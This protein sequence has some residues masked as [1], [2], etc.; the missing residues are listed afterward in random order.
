[1]PALP[2]RADEQ[3]KSQNARVPNRVVMGLLGVVAVATI[4]F[5]VSRARRNSLSLKRAAAGRFSA[6]CDNPRHG[7]WNRKDSIDSPLVAVRPAI[8]SAIKGGSTKS[9]RR[10][11]VCQN[12]VAKMMNKQEFKHLFKVKK[13]YIGTIYI[14]EIIL[15]FMLKFTGQRTGQRL[16]TAAACPSCY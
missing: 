7:L 11:R 2:G 14:Q 16:V 8:L 10:T 15:N 3:L 6:A 1:M 12:C 4:V 9:N 5:A 13:K